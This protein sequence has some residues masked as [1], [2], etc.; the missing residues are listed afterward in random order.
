MV[1]RRNAYTLKTAC[2]GEAKQRLNGWNPLNNRA[3]LPITPSGD[4]RLHQAD[5]YV[6]HLASQ[7]PEQL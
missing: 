1:E 5:R 3:I 2:C 6:H 4:H 7:I